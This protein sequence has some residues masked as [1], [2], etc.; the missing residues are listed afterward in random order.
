M[1][2]KKIQLLFQ[3]IPKL[4]TFILSAIVVVLALIVALVYMHVAFLRDDVI[5]EAS[6][7]A[8]VSFRVHYLENDIFFESPVPHNLKFLMSFTDFI[9]IDSQ[10]NARFSEEVEVFYS[11]TARKRVAINHMV[12]GDANLNPIVF[13]R[14][15]LIS[16]GEGSAITD[17]M[18]FTYG[19]DGPGGT[20]V[21]YPRDFI[22]YYHDFIA[23]H[24]YQM[25]ATNVLPRNLRG[26]SADLFVDF[27]YT[28]S[29]PEW[30]FRETVSNGY[31]MPI[32]TETYFLTVN[33]GNGDNGDIG[34]HSFERYIDLTPPAPRLTL[35]VIIIYTLILAL[36]L[37][38]LLDGLKRQKAEHNKY[39]K[40]ANS[41]LKKY[42][43]EIA[44]SKDPLQLEEYTMMRAE[45]FDVLLRLAINLNKH[46][47]CY[48]DRRH[49]EFAVLVEE[50][51]YYYRIDFYK[52]G[53]GS[54]NG[55]HKSNDNSNGKNKN[56]GN[57]NHKNNVNSNGNYKSNGNGNSS[58]N[59]NKRKRKN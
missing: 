39:R 58:G 57:G 43:D 11:Y 50:F 6:G 4:W 53:N 18:E 5:G 21:I 45:E 26:F 52:S 23:A 37:Y 34:S 28:I 13:E 17:Q 44:T 49:V 29:I 20:Y 15:W 55:N 32:T 47:M 9:E 30:D 33:S 31:R 12:T 40:K 59:G 51:A 54:S 46:I 24:E 16:Q 10:F 22:D 2:F 25:I 1:E 19:I 42:K 35:P 48:Q 7:S 27:I 36:G 14:Y 41:I 3:K 8:S 56:N 38:G